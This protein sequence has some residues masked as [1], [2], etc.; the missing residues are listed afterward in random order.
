MDQFNARVLADSVSPNKVRLTTLE[1]TFP[2][3]ILAEF[4]THRRFSRNSASSRAIP[5]HKQINRVLKW[6]FVP[7]AFGTKQPGMS[8]GDDLLGLKAWVAR[9]LWLKS[10]YA[11]VGA[12]KALDKL[13]VHKSW[14]NRLLEPWLWHT[15]IVTSSAW[16]NFFALRIDEGAQ[17]E[18][19]K[20]A[21]MMQ[22][23]LLDSFP[24]KLNPGEW[25]LPLV[26]V[27]DEMYAEAMPDWDELDLPMVSAGRC[28]RVS[29][30]RQHDKEEIEKSF[31]RS[32]RFPKEGHW[33]PLEHQAV[34]T[35]GH[36]DLSGNFH[37]DWAQ[38]R[39]M[40]EHEDNFKELKEANAA[41]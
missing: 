2:R 10:R 36:D 3:L 38:F 16:E 24:V 15:V 1:V 30:D 21:E 6:P 8:A 34:V 28:A 27:A 25:H 23:A 41:K 35:D 5:V 19:R 18:I 14:A 12:A 39:K 40:F 17:P 33:S 20:I 29:F 22:Y 7:M 13:G 31:Y 32:K 4:N 9:Q 11:A 37:G 26:N